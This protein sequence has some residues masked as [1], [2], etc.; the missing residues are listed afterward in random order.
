MHNEIDD[1][2]ERFSEEAEKAVVGSILR[3]PDSIAQI[4]SSLGPDDFYS[5][6]H[7]TIYRALLEMF[8]VGEA[9]DVVTVGEKLAREGTLVNADGFDVGGAPALI[10]LLFDE[11]LTAANI[12]HYADIVA[13]HAA[14]RRLESF[15]RAGLDAV[16]RRSGPPDLL[17]AEA[18]KK[19]GRVM[20]A[21]AQDRLV[22]ISD[23]GL[24]LAA[25]IDDAKNQDPQSLRGLRTGLAL[26]DNAM[27]LMPGETTIVGARTSVGKTAFALSVAINAAKDGKR[28]LFV[29]LEMS[30]ALLGQRAISAMSGVK[31]HLIRKHLFQDEDLTSMAGAINQPEGTRILVLDSPGATLSRIAA[32]ARRAHLRQP[33]DLII[34]DYLGL[35]EPEDRRI[36]RFEHIGQTSRGLKLL[37]RSLAVPV[38]VLAQLNRELEKRSDPRPRLSD[39][40]ESG[41]IEQDAD[42]VLFLHRPWLYDEKKD[43]TLVEI[44]IAKNRSGPVGTIDVTFDPEYTRF[45]NRQE[46]PAA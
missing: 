39:L 40:R 42:S 27:E 38:M 22:S 41:S 21:S 34:V 19:L 24:D 45:S 11:T 33:L 31:L 8:S 2:I 14:W 16:L 28:V 5:L 18:E 7:Q 3:K 29:S 4:A 20:R 17:V 32:A 37:S 43:K 46:C 9:I 23:L 35:I 1:Q 10:R 15:Y 13:R 6:A 36:N 44:G 12:V 26:L 30:A 25:K